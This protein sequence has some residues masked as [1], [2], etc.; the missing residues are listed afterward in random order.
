MIII[1]CAPGTYQALS[2]ALFY[3]PNER[4][5]EIDVDVFTL[6]EVEAQKD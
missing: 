6:S 3:L 4:L 5:Y 1:P 2:H